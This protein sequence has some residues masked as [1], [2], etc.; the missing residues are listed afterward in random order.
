M[1]ENSQEN[2]S[3][4][5]KTLEYETIYFILHTHLRYSDSV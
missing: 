5:T 3:Y 2:Y 4:L 1:A